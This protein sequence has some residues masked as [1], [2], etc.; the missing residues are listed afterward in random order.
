[1][2]GTTSNGATGQLPIKSEATTVTNKGRTGLSRR[3]WTLIGI[4]VLLN[5]LFFSS[6]LCIFT[7]VYQIVDD[8]GDSANIASEVLTLVSVSVQIYNAWSLLTTQ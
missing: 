8:P 5:V 2:A 7:Q 6:L 3:Q 1:M 4:T